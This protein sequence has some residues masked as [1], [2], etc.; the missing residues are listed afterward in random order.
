MKHRQTWRLLSCPRLR[1]AVNPY[2]VHQHG[3][4]KNCGCIWMSRPVSAHRCVQQEEERVIVDPLRSLG[5]I[6]RSAGGVE[7]FIDEETDLVRFPFHSEDVK[8]IR[9]SLLSWQTVSRCD[10]T[11][12]RISRPVN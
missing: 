4:R 2:V 10:A 12:A 5:K 1:S 3:L 11:L 9:E 8:V 6:G 7:V